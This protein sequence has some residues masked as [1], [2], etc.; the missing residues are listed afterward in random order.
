M[1]LRV[2]Y[3]ALAILGI[4]TACAFVGVLG[5]PDLPPFASPPTSLPHWEYR[6]QIAV[7][8]ALEAAVFPAIFIFVLWRVQILQQRIASNLCIRCGYDLR[9]TPDRCP[10]C[11]E[12]PEKV[13]FAP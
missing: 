2:Q 12:V 9:A 10:E 7:L 4:S 13:K 8:I 6:T 3:R 5:L 1:R 11:G